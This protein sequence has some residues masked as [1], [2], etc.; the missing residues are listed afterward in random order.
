[1]FVSRKTIDGTWQNFERLVCR[2]LNYKGFDGARVVGT[3]GDKGVDVIAH[4]G[5]KR[6]V[7]QVKH[8]N[9]PVSRVD[10]TKTVSAMS[11]YK[12]QIPAIVSR[13]GFDQPARQQRE[14]LFAQGVPFQLWDSHDLLGNAKKIDSEAYPP[15]FEIYHQIRPYQETAIQRLRAQFQ[16]GYSR[17]A[18]IV[19]ATGLGKTRVM[20]EFIRRVGIP[21]KM[22]VLVI[23]HTN[24]LVYQ[25]ERAFWPFMRANQNSPRLEWHGKPNF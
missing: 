25:L 17:K 15:G 10:I 1:M 11:F 22:K 23:A 20:C 9:K 18:M 4:K 3:T 8:W 19:M 6:W 5:G 7:F 21:K 12:A 24:D 13:S 16:S 2:Y 14:E